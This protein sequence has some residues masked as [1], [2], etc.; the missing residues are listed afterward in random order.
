M[1][2]SLTGH[3]ALMGFVETGQSFQ[4]NSGAER[5]SQARQDQ[6]PHRSVLSEALKDRRDLLGEFKIHRVGRR[7][8]QGN[9]G[10]RTLVHNI[11]HA[12]CHV[13]LPC[14]A[15]EFFVILAINPR[16]VADLYSAASRCPPGPARPRATS[17]DL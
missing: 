1:A 9:E 2:G 5:F 15:V 16:P 6:G 7:T 11:N 4:I 8:P 13:A 3:P 12:C 14:R 17:I 10:D